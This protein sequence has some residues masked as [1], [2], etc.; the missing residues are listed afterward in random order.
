MLAG[1]PRIV[2][3]LP[4]GEP[5]AP[6]DRIEI[7][8]DAPI[9][10]SSFTLSD[11]VMLGP[12][13]EITPSA[14]SQLSPDR[15]ELVAN[16]ATG[17]EHYLLSIGPDVVDTVG[18]LMDQ[19]DDDVAGETVEDIYQANLYASEGEITESDH[20]SDGRALIVHATTLTIDGSHRVCCD[21]DPRGRDAN[22]FGNNFSAGL[23]DGPGGQRS[24]VDRRQKR[25]Q[26]DG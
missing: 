12:S 4:A 22:T 26:R 11:V 25:S 1:G 23:R 17:L 16:G 18:R 19:D 6:F 3:L 2:E 5:D 21:R 14:V 20:D 7:Q 13:G 10:E 8:F 15:F 24:T 9:Q